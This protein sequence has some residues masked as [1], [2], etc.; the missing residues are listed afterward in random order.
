[1]DTP[2][3][4]RRLAGKTLVALGHILLI[5]AAILVPVAFAADLIDTFPALGIAALVILAGMLLLLGGDRLADGPPVRRD[6]SV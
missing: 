3:Q 4:L 6:L 2:R 1:M 5:V